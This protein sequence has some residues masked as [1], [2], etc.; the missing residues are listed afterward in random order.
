ME[1]E[2]Q[3]NSIVN[4][5]ISKDGQ[6]GPV[7]AAAIGSCQTGNNNRTAA[8]YSFSKLNQN[9]LSCHDEYVTEN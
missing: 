6:V 4:D 9:S 1:T 5:G 3:R 8:M 2:I 7:G